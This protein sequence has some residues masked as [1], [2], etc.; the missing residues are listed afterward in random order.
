MG[1]IDVGPV[2]PARVAHRSIRPP[3]FKMWCKHG[4][5]VG[6]SEG[7]HESGRGARVEKENTVAVEK[8]REER[9]EY[10]SPTKAMFRNSRC[11]WG[12]H[13]GTCFF[14]DK[15]LGSVI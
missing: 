4:G 5:L 11:F 1:G 6:T 13:I 15:P 2:Q 7:D 10:A 9:F 12:E 8:E 3:S 14:L